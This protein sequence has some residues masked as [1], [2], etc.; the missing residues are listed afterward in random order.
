MATLLIVED[1]KDLQQVLSYNLTLAGHVPILASGGG[2]G[3]QKA[4]TRHPDLILL[5][6]MLPDLPG[7][8]VCRFLKQDPLLRTIPVIF[9]SARGEEHDRIQGLE[10]GAEDYVVKPFSVR[11]L[12]LRIQRLLQRGQ[13][14]APSADPCLVFGVLKIDPEAHRVWVETEAIDLTALE[15]KLL[16]TLYTRGA[17]VQTRANLLEQVWG[18]SGEL[19]TRTVDTHVKR[20]REKLGAAAGY[21]ETV[22]GVGYRFAETFGGHGG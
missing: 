11:E 3:L 10:L 15:F 13:T 6:V 1:E 19:E 17:R 16:M 9:L 20:L 14:G 4:R 21:I 12:L 7:T 8:E 18:M 5:D 2:E 22:R